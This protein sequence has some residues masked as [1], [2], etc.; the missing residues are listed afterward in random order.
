MSFSLPARL[1]RTA[2][3]LTFDMPTEGTIVT[4]GEIEVTI[5]RRKP[6]PMVHPTD[7][8]EVKSWEC[9]TSLAPE[10][11]GACT[12]WKSGDPDRPGFHG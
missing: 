9:L 12:C 7:R 6:A 3:A 4:D 5:R 2:R 8:R 11:C 1:L 10:R